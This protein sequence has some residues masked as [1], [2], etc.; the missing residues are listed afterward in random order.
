VN[1]D[2]TPKAGPNVKVICCGNALGQPI[3]PYLVLPGKTW[4]PELLEGVTAGATGE[5]SPKG[6][7]VCID[8]HVNV[9]K[10]KVCVS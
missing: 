1:P 10:K 6:A 9:H 7:Y 8:V 5:A 2:A 4:H 3:P